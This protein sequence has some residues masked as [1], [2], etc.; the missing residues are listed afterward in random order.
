MI[1]VTIDDWGPDESIHVKR[2]LE[3]L[4]YV[5]ERDFTFAY[6]PPIWVHIQENEHQFAEWKR[7]EQKVTYTFHNEAAASWFRLK[8]E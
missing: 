5:Y 7:N 2:E 8:Y 1:E 6:T 4:G 3:N